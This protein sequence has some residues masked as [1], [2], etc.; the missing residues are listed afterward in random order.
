MTLERLNNGEVNMPI[1]IIVAEPHGYCGNDKFGVAGAIKIAQDTAQQYPGQ[2]YILGEIVHNQ[3]VVDWLA[4]KYGVKTVHNLA[5]IPQGETVVI[6]AH[7]A[8]P[9][10]YTEAEERGLHV[11]DATCPLVK[12]AHHDVKI[13]AAQ[14]KKIIYIASALDHDEAI[15]VA[16]EEP[17]A[18]ALTTLKELD[19]V[20]IQDP[21]KTVILTQTTLSILETKERL[22]GLKEKHPSLEIKPH[23]CMATTQ[24]QEAVIKLAKEIGFVIVVG[25]PTSSNSNR[26]REVAEAVGA[27]AYIVDT[28]E[29]LNPDWFKGIGQMGVT[30]GA[31]TPEW[32]LDEVI[33]TI[34]EITP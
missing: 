12:R 28:A 9:Q 18:V 14:G 11:V 10:T 22:A 26:L 30:S 32:I 4:E 3:H 27:T 25:H 24:R 17:E 2:T 34:K 31:S 33:K 29:E 16:G 21:G 23:I 5:E 19:K 13:L 20:E 1:K 6:R 15:G 7:G 8:V